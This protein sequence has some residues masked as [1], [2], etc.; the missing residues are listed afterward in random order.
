MSDLH[1][2]RL[3]A[4]LEK[5][6]TSL[7]DMT[8]YETRPKDKRSAFISRALAA[9]ALVVLEGATDAAAAAAIVDG[10]DD[11]GVD[12]VYYNSDDQKLV[13]CQSKWKD[14]GTAS[15]DQGAVK[16]FLSGVDMLVNQKL[17]RF[18]SRLERHQET[19][20][21]ALRDADVKFKMVLTHNGVSPLGDHVRQDLEDF[22]EKGNNPS[23]LFSLE[24]LDQGRNYQ[25]LVGQRGGKPIIIEVGLREWG[26]LTEP[27]AAYYGQVP[28]REIAGWWQQYGRDLLAKNIRSFK[29]A[30]DVND[31]MAETLSSSASDFWYFNNGITLLCSTVKRALAGSGN[32]EFGH[33]AC[34]GVSVVNGAQTVGQIG[35]FPT[36]DKIPDSARVLVRIISLEGVPEGF[37]QRITRATNTQNRVEGRD[38]AS[39]DE[40]QRRIR[41]ELALD[42]IEYSIRSGDPLPD[43]K[44]GCTISEAAVA[45]A[46]AQPDVSLAVLVKNQVGRVFEDLQAPPYT[47]LFNSATPA[48]EVWR[49]VSVMR[50]VDMIVEAASYTDEQRAMLLAV[51]GN[52]FILHMVF[53]DPALVQ[54]RNEKVTIDQLR[55]DAAQ[56]A[57]TAFRRLLD[58]LNLHQ[59]NAYLQPLFKTQDRCKE[60]ESGL[61]LAPAAKQPAPAPIPPSPPSKHTPGMLP[62]DKLK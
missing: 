61:A 29:G 15:I 48:R 9:Y 57:A 44:D 2:N 50:I 33:F 41:R 23:E 55:K 56:A 21:S 14:D 30:T 20:E 32:R 16:K 62:F 58:Y 7:I 47:L 17:D 60:L 46:C 45:M 28:V 5:R 8:D 11:N 6:F 34:T 13:V 36:P 3:R 43:P 35:T 38:F 59:P 51:N 24:V 1:V 54:W 52:R 22:L 27:Y 19:I 49:A 53:R 18:G 39:L 40:N 4:E 12:A 37:D 31:G 42:G 10:Y 25:A 26:C